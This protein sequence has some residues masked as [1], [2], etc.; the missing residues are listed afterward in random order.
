MRIQADPQLSSKAALRSG[1][2]LGLALGIIHSVISILV[3]Q[4]TSYSLETGNNPGTLPIIL[5]LLTPLIWI[6]GLLVAGAMG[7]RAT[8]KV[9]T[10]L[11]A[12]LLAGT[13]GGVLA[14]FG[15]VIATAIAT[16]QTPSNSNSTTL[17]FIGFAAIFYVLLLA[18]A[19]GT[20]LGALGGLIGQSLSNVRPQPPVQQIYM[21]PVQPAPYTY[22]APQ[23]APF[24]APQPQPAPFS[25]PVVPAP[26]QPPVPP[27]PEQ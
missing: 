1:A 6:V 10:G 24:V 7:S 13:F 3:T 20:G 15:Q 11:L 16:N 5:Y 26:G 21:A 17:L 9:S 25:Q 23:P 22:A 27:Q 14:G 2:T 12:G 19:A 8:G 4:I 18:I